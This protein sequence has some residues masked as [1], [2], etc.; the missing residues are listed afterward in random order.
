MV[1][2]N[3]QNLLLHQDLLIMVTVKINRPTRTQFAYP[4]IGDRHGIRMKKTIM[5]H[6]SQKEEYELETGSSNAQLLPRQR[7]MTQGP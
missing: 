1:I 7:G 4:L 2:V 5:S 3:R 6:G